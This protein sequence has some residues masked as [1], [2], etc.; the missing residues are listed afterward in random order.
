[1]PVASN[2]FA[3]FHP[4][5]AV[6][7]D[8]RARLERGE[9]VAKAL[10]PADRELA[11]FSAARA[12]FTGDRLVAWVR[13]IDA[14]K[15]GKYAPAV[16]R[17]SQ[18][19]QISDLASL[20]LEP[21]DL[22]ELRRC[23]PGSCGLKLSELEIRTLGSIA[24]AGRDDWR[25]TLQQA[26]RE[27]MLARAHAYLNE[28]LAGAPPY[29]DR[30]EPVLLEAEFQQILTN[31]AFLSTQ[32]PTL[33]DFLARYPTV[34][35]ADL[36]SFLYWSKETLGRRP[37]VSITHVT[38]A[39]HHAGPLPDAV[40]AARQVFATHYSTGSLSLTAIVGGRDGAPRYLVYLNRSRLD[41]LGGLFGG[42]ARRIIERRFRDEAVQVVESLRGRLT[43]GEPPSEN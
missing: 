25:A 16:G 20:E 33:T 30:S 7:L 12:E 29:R 1:M 6:S 40:V 15:K 31:S 3:F 19:P 5:V 4:Q 34:P 42:L 8:E 38:I 22:D 24:S 17:F 28:G 43:A 41:V 39:R 35:A 27:T 13:R 9:A 26:F 36:E 10:P 14:L 11:V 23:R 21:A 32:I 18:P 2:P 37:I